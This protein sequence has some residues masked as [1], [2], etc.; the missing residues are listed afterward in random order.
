MAFNPLLTQCQPGGRLGRGGLEENLEEAHRR[1]ASGSGGVVLWFAA[2]ITTVVS[3]FHWFPL[4]L[5][6]GIVGV[7]GSAFAIYGS[8]W[9]LDLGLNLKVRNDSN[10]LHTSA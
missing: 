2:A 8:Q 3:T 1:W 7:L 6:S 5:S 4:G 10:A 9:G